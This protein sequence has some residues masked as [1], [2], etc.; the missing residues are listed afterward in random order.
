M[1]I[2]MPRWQSYMATTTEPMFSPEQCQDIIN[3]GHAEKPQTAQVGMNRPGGGVDK[4]KRT[5]TI[6]WIPFKK[7]PQMYK[8]VEHQLSLVN[9]NHFGFEN[10]QITEPAQF[11]EYPKGGFYD[12]HMDLDVKGQ[13]E[14][15]VRKISMTCLLSDPS[16]FTG[17]EL[18]FMEKNK[19]PNLKQ[20]QAIF[21]ASFLRHRVAPVKKGTRRS[22]VMWFGG[23]PFK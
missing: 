3:A 5:T 18:E 19:I 12:W 17:G 10:V 1:I 14:P 13:H 22:L 16:T 8:K 2:K 9:L 4:K 23:Q 11:T 6:S 7:L 20:G 15:P 21:F